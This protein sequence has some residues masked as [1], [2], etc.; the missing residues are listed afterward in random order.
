MNLE[1]G[2]GSGKQFNSASGQSRH[3][4]KSFISTVFDALCA[5][6][7]AKSEAGKLGDECQGKLLGLISTSI[8]VDLSDLHVIQGWEG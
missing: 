3:S 2:L 1:A 5:Q 4:F 6:S 7:I 8:A